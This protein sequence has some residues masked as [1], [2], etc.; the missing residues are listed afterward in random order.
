MY[1]CFSQFVLLF[2]CLVG[3][4]QEYSP[5]AESIP[6]IPPGR[7]AARPKEEGSAE[8]SA[9]AIGKKAA[10]NALARPKK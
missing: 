2:V 10:G 6:D 9:P 4:A 1:K 3:C 8:A 7:S 5:P